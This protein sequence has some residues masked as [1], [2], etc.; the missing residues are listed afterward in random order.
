MQSTS[1][2]DIQD[3][4]RATDKWMAHEL[5]DAEDPNRSNGERTDS[6]P[7]CHKLQRKPKN[8]KKK[9]GKQKDKPP[10]QGGPALTEVSSDSEGECRSS[11]GRKPKP[12][13]PLPPTHKSRTEPRDKTK[14]QSRI[15]GKPPA[16][17]YVNTRTDSS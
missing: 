7:S 6:D 11:D 10:T 17:T 1:R 13:K 3:I 8:A 9:T 16:S 4:Q 5:G 14:P 2:S 12:T 15:S